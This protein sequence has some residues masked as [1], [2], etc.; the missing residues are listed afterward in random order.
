MEFICLVQSRI[1]YGGSFLYEFNHKWSILFLQELEKWW[2]Q[3]K[4]PIRIDSLIYFT[5][6]FFDKQD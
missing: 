5:N 1:W 6:N 3:N 4:F 2:H